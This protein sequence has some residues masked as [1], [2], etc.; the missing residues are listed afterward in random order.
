MARVTGIGGI[1]LKARDPDALRAWYRD[2]L[3][4]PIDTWGGATFRWRDGMKES[5]DGLTVWSVFPVESTLTFCKIVEV[6]AS[7]I[8][9]GRVNSTSTLAFG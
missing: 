2:H 3:G 7:A 8:D 6:V 1:F 9:P 4:I 5:E